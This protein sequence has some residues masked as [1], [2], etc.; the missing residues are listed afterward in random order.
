MEID[1]NDDPVAMYLR[2]AANVQPLTK[3]EETALIKE[4]SLLDRRNPQR[5]TAARRLIE[6]HLQAVVDIAEKYSSSG[7]PMLEL[8]EEGNLGL[9][10]AVDR[11]VKQPNGDFRE[12]AATLIEEAIRRCVSE[13]E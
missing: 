9:M 8:L 10:E 7:V 4:L 2:E 6:G 12:F 5:E 1:N 11:F 3:D 13:S